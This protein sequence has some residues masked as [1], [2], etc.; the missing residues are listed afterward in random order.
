MSLEADSTAFMFL[1]RIRKELKEIG[2]K[3]SCVEA[4]KLCAVVR[5]W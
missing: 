4:C 5:V 1:L 2:V 3:R